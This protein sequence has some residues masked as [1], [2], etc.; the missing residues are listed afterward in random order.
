MKRA[1]CLWILVLASGLLTPLP[2]IA[3]QPAAQP[4]QSGQQDLAKALSNPLAALVS[5]PLQFNWE[6]GVGPDESLRMVLNIQPVVPFKL[7]DQWNLIGRLILPIVSQPALIE[8]GSSNFGTSDILL[9]TFVSPSQPKGA[10]WGVGPVVGLP[11]TTNPFLGSGKWSVGPTAVALK[12]AGAW[13][14]GALVNH[15]WSYAS[16]SR[17]ARDRAGVNQTFLQPFLSYSTAG[18]VTVGL[19]AEASANWEASEGNVWTI[20]INLVV[21]KMSSFGPF[22][23]QIGGGVAV[24]AASPDGGPTWRLRT[25][26]VLLLPR[27]R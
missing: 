25:Q 4:A 17:S 9:S 23:F 8:G 24:Y 13:T 6:N 26:F 27:Q 16:V 2:A 21:A 12:Q 1:F 22:P 5:V 3:Q 14:Y 19:N 11:T 7:N 20:P 18:G 15:L 10:V